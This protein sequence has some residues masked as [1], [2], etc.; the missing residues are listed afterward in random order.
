M[1]IRQ[2][3]VSVLGHVDHGKT[4]LL[5]TIRGTTVASREAGAITQHIGAT[6]V[7]LKVINSICGEMTGGKKFSVPGLLFIDT[8]GHQ[9]FREMRRRGGTLA[10]IAVLVID[11]NEGLK[12]Q[13]Q[14]SISILRRCGTPFIVALNKID[15]IP[16]WRRGEGVGP[17]SKSLERQTEAM[18]GQLDER[19]YKIIGKLHDLGVQADKYTQITD[20]KAMNAMVPVVARTGEGIPDLLLVLI[21]IA[22]RFM[23]E[24][25]TIEEEGPGEGTILEVKEEKGLGPT[26]DV[27]LYKGV[28]RL[29]DTIAVGTASE[30]KITKVR[31]ILKP[32]PL[33]EIRDPKERFDPRSE[34]SAAAGIK[35]VGQDVTGAIAGGPIRVMS[36]D[37][38]KIMKEMENEAKVSI[39]T[40]EGGIIIKADALGSLEAIC[41]EAENAGIKISKAEVGDV[42][43]RDIV[44]AGTCGDAMNHVILGFNVQVLPDAK[45]EMLSCDVQIIT[46]DIIYRLIQDYQAWLGKAKRVKD[47]DLR[48]EIVHPGKVLLLPDCVFR[49]S[50]PA[51]VGV[52]VLAGRVRPGQKLIKSDGKEGGKIKSIRSGENTI[53]E[54]LQGAEV[55]LALEGPTVGRQ[56]NVGDVMYVD[57]PEEHARRL[58]TAALNVDEKDALASLYK[59][60]EKEK[61]Y[62]GR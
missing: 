49:V 12:P 4:T 7:P 30:P 17:L 14:E 27:I 33:D 10:D 45:E 40:T 55:A 60:K 39:K 46:G 24:S 6:E 53:K 29:G 59:I 48:E 26:L 9:S 2:P 13:T 57:M 28:L 41:F 35:V 8:P 54:A 11:I 31:A 25:L 52:R 18:R 47:A 61:R 51:I 32:K 15:L 42:S 3:I 44:G 1:P 16:G 21:G 34:I 23:E 62:W 43:R 36:G 56:I 20:F 5:D 37:L 19:I 50:K 22:Q 58:Q 38:A